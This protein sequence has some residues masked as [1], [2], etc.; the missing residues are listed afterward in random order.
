MKKNNII[1][2]TILKNTNNNAQMILLAGITIS[3]LIIMLSSV[4]ANISN[5]DATLSY[6]INVNPLE[7]YLNA[8]EVFISV[9]KETCNCEGLTGDDLTDAIT[10][11]FDHTTKTLANIQIKYGYYFTAEIS[12]PPFE[13]YDPE[14][15]GPPLYK[16]VGVHI[17]LIIKE[18]TIEEDIRIPILISS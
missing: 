5:Y 1:Q 13:D 3:I 14:P 10:N 8:R 7:E 6:E 17:R 15:V 16:E 18:T 9:F 12:D 11:A 2:K 4:A